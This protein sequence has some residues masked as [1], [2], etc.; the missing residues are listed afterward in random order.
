[1]RARKNVMSMAHPRSGCAD[2]ATAGRRSTAAM[3][4]S[5]EQMAMSVELPRSSFRRK[6]E[7]ILLCVLV[8]QNG[9][10]LYSR[11]ALALR[12]S[13]AVRSLRLQ[14]PE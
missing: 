4:S 2:Y 11:R 13:F 5:V 14:S 3:R 1:M 8:D 7:S 9:F 6:P 10:R 12:A